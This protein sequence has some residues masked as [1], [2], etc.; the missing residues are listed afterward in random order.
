MLS[1]DKGHSNV[2]KLLLDYGALIN[3]NN[4][5][6]RSALMIASR[7]GHREVTQLLLENGVKTDF[8]GSDLSLV[9]SEDHTSKVQQLAMYTK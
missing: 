3:L 2:A 9:T 8:Q 4:N 5:Y 6:G 7:Q 1:S